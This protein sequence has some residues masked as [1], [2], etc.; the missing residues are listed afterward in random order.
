VIKKIQNSWYVSTHLPDHEKTGHYSRRSESFSSEAEAKQFAAAKIAA[1][2]EVNAGTLNPVTPKRI[3][4][5][6]EIEKW[7]SEKTNKPAG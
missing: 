2:S 4:R 7:L 6:S 3:V 5:P 1:G